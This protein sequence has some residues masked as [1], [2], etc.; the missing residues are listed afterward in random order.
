MGVKYIFRLQSTNMYEKEKRSMTTND[1]WVKLKVDER[2]A[3]LVNTTQQKPNKSL[4][5]CEVE[6]PISVQI[7][8][9]SLQLILFLKNI[10]EN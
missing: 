9:E 4:F 3:V 10:R 2:K 7:Y 1:E 5:I 8:F 6:K